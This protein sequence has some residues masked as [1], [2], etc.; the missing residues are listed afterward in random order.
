MISKNKIKYITSLNIKKFRLENRQFIAEGDKIVKALME[1]TNIK[2]TDIFAVEDWISKNISKIPEYIN[3][4]RVSDNELKKI[5]NQQSP[6]QV[7]AIADIPEYKL[8]V[9]KLKNLTI[10]LDKIQDPGNLGTII[11]TSAWFG[12]KDIICSD[13]SVDV[14]NAKVIQA[15]MG[16]IATVKVHYANLTDILKYAAFNNINVY[17]TF[18]TGNNIYQ[19]D[20]KL[21]A[22]VLF[23]NEANGISENLIDFINYKIQIPARLNNTNIVESL[24][25]SSSVAIVCSEFFRRIV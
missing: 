10:L 4:N 19:Q 9:N 13:N 16:A 21:P 22:F 18:L 20:L 8:E 2:V 17:G 12:I 15:S 14:F 23:G 7:I 3:V 11:R 6:N 24:N 5:S 25:L 1:A